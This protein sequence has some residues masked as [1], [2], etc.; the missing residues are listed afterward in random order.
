[1]CADSYYYCNC[2]LAR[3]NA[4]RGMYTAISINVVGQ[5][6]RQDCKVTWVIY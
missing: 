3:A 6:S 2:A 5:P 4:L 1:M